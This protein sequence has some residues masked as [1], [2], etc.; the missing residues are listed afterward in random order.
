MRHLFSACHASLRDN[1]ERP[2]TV[3]LGA[4]QIVGNRPEAIIAAV[5]AS[6][7]QRPGP[8]RVPE[9]W[10]GAAARRIV[11]ILLD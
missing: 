10:D 5:R 4:N 11:E 9:K 2:I 1:T 3:A 8:L 6:L 7:A